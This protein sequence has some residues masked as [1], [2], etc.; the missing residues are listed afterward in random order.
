M[1][2]RWLNDSATSR[3]LSV[4][5]LSTTI[6]SARIPSR[7]ADAR[8]SRVTFSESAR[9]RVQITTEMF[10]TGSFILAPIVS[11]SLTVKKLSQMAIPE[12]PNQLVNG[13][14]NFSEHGPSG[15]I[16][17]RGIAVMNLLDF[18]CR[19]AA[20]VECEIHQI[21]FQRSPAPLISEQTLIRHSGASETIN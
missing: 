13:P 11:L 10:G 7:L 16:G 3:A 15:A 4:P 20:C 2:I 14:G 1:R 6:T 21:F 5:E 19:N 18:F 9:L 12:I 17:Q 8:H